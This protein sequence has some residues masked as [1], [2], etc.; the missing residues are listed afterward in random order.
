MVGYLVLVTLLVVW[1]VKVMMW[2]IMM[3]LVYGLLLDKMELEKEN[4]YY[5]LIIQIFLVGSLVLVPLLDIMLE[6][7]VEEMVLHIIIQLG[8]G[9]QLVMM[10]II[11]DIIYY[12]LIIQTYRVGHNVLVLFLVGQVIILE[13]VLYIMILIIYGLLLEQQL[14]LIVYYIHMI[15]LI[16]VLQH[17]H[18]SLIFL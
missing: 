2:H 3:H 17:G 16:L 14:Q 15:Q 4:I 18:P 5:I 11:Q 7:M 6:L 9:L 10:Q 8:Y 13:I 12:I 1:A